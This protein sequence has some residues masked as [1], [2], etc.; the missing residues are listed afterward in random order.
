MTDGGISSTKRKLEIGMV[1]K[2]MGKG[3]YS[4]RTTAQFLKIWQSWNSNSGHVAGSRRVLLP[5]PHPFDTFQFSS[6]DTFQC[7]I[8]VVLLQ[9][10]IMPSIYPSTQQWKSDG[11]LSSDN[12]EGSF[13]QSDCVQHVVLGR[14]D[15]SWVRRNLEWSLLFNQ[16]S[17]RRAAVYQHRHQPSTP[18][19]LYIALFLVPIDEMIFSAIGNERLRFDVIVI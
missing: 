4:E 5:L 11:K 9:Q 14:T 18:F 19:R 13:K 3:E 16:R 7:A 17:E 8:I 12:K 1:F 2:E 15:Y 10:E 6:V